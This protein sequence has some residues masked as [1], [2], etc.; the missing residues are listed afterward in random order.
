MASDNSWGAGVWAAA[1]LATPM[2]VRVA[3]TLRV[4]DH[5]VAGR[6]T[7][8]V[9]AEA[10]GVHADALERVLR[11]LVTAGVLREDGEAGYQLTELGDG[12]RDDHPHG[13][14]RWIDLDGA[15]GYADLCFT[16]LLHTVRTGDPAFPARYGI[17]YWDDLDENPARAASFDA[18][19][20]GRLNS[21]MPEIVRAVDWAALGSLVDVGGG[22]GSLLIALL[23]A[24]PDLH[25]TVLDLPGPAR[26]AASAIA[27][28]GLGDRA[29]ATS[30]SFFDPLPAS[31][32]GCLLSGV[33]HDWDDRSATAI[34]RRCA[35]AV[36]PSGSVFVIETFDVDEDTP[37]STEMDLRMLAYVGGRE[38]SIRELRELADAATLELNS[39]SPVTDHSIVELKPR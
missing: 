18:L 12:L 31:A 2:T 33:L 25:G 23:H 16:E 21:V 7:A 32:G 22:D 9:I 26:A 17:G 15:T 38:R 14:R 3:A 13:V 20:G 30:A 28:A 5:I 39:V 4:A 35:E 36:R 29:K 34:L 37:G 8:P 19:M 6:R 11:H 1:D 27:D 24:H 10:A